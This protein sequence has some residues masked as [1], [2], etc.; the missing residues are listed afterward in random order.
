MI[1]LGSIRRKSWPEY[2]YCW[3]IPN[4]EE[5]NEDEDELVGWNSAMKTEEEE[6][7]MV[8]EDVAVEEAPTPE[9]EPEI[10]MVSR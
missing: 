4:G 2:W 7:V 6:V 1:L 3:L 10:A 9:P 5:E 8:H